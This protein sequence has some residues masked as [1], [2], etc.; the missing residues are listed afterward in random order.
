MATSSRD[1][2]LERE[3][4]AKPGISRIFHEIDKLS[5]KEQENNLFIQ[6]SRNE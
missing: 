1:V 5:D 6:E 2:F 4:Y 3:K